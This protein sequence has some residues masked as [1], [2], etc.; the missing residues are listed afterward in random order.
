MRTIWQQN[1][2][3]RLQVNICRHYGDR[4]EIRDYSGG[5]AQIDDEIDEKLNFRNCPKS[6]ISL[7]ASRYD[8]MNMCYFPIGGMKKQ[9]DAILE[10]FGTT[11]EIILFTHSLTVNNLLF[12]SFLLFKTLKFPLLSPFL[13]FEIIL[14]QI[15]T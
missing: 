15:L 10:S 4:G 1:W 6:T 11:K 7:L 9:H 12:S 14:S 8:T 3:L 5:I 2:R 13:I